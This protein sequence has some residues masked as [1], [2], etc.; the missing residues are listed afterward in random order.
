MSKDLIPQFL[1]EILLIIERILKVSDL[2]D[3]ISA[4]TSHC[5]VEQEASFSEYFFL[6]S[7]TKYLP[8]CSK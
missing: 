2:F 3:S 7:Q 1:L 6:Y 8:K 4:S 5:D